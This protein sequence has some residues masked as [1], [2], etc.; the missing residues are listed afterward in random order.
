MA[1]QPSSA[2]HSQIDAALKSGIEQMKS[3]ADAMKKV[4][5][6]SVAVAKH[7]ALQQ[8]HASARGGG[9]AAPRQKSAKGTTR[10]RVS[11]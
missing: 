6:A 7:R 11:K 2:G 8:K 9:T 4:G 5:A 1:T 10:K 3:H